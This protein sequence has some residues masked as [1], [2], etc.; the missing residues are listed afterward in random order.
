MSSA[1]AADDSSS[2]EPREI[3]ERIAAGIGADVSISARER[4]GVVTVTRLR[5]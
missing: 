1:S 5:P 2:G 3:V 4:D